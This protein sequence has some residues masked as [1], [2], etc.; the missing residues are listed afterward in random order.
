MAVGDNASRLAPAK[1]S[2]AALPGHGQLCW[3]WH[4]LDGMIVTWQGS[5]AVNC[6][7]K[8]STEYELLQLKKA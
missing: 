6:A 5:T 3:G 4:L 8:Q 1:T 7:K 2:L